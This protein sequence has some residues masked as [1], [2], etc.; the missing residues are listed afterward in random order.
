MYWVYWSVLVYDVQRFADLWIQRV[1]GVV[2][3]EVCACHAAYG[4]FVCGISDHYT[5][6]VFGDVNC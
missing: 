4:V 2:M 5:F 6:S 1:Q 3:V